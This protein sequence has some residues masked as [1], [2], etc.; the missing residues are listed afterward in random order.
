MGGSGNKAAARRFMEVVLGTGD[1]DGAEDILDPD[2][3]MIHP[4]SPEP[5]RGFDAVKGMLSGFRAAFPDLTITAEEEVGEGDKVVVRWTFRGTHTA[6]L[7][8][9]PATNKHAE[10][11]GMSWFTFAADGKI[12]EDRVCEDT[13]GL[14]RQLGVAPG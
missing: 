4:S 3:V 10:M 9:L 6:D 5:V 12:V 14:M 2:V 8:G 7:F 13:L 1:W 11:P